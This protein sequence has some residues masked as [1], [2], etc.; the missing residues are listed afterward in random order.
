M[1]DPCLADHML[2]CAQKPSVSEPGQVP[3]L[4]GQLHE[5]NF[6]LG[7][8]MW[9]GGGHEERGLVEG[10]GWQCQKLASVGEEHLPGIHLPA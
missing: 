4:E 7:M 6:M 1:N 10:Q 2:M 3:S 5:T 9:G 8:V